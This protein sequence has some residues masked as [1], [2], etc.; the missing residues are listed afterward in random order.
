LDSFLLICTRAQVDAVLAEISRLEGSEFPYRHSE[1]ALSEVRRLFREHL[2]SLSGLVGEGYVPDED[3][4][5]TACAAACDSI[6]KSLDILGF[7]LRSTNVRNAFEIHGP[8]L[9]LAR[10]VLNSTVRKE[11]GLEWEI[12]DDELPDTEVPETKLLISSEW[13]FSPFTLVG[14]EELPGFVLIGLPATESSNPLLIP[15]AGH[16]LGHTI[17]H[18]FQGRKRILQ[19]VSDKIV[20]EVKTTHWHVLKQLFPGLDPATLTA[21]V[22]FKRSELQQA[23]EWAMRQSEEVFCDCVGLRIFGESYLHAFAYLVVPLRE[24]GRSPIYPNHLARV[25]SLVTTATTYGLSVPDGYAL[26]FKDLLELNPDPIV[27]SLVSVADTARC[28]ASHT[29]ASMAN[30]ILTTADIPARSP[31]KVQESV[32]TFRLMVPV[33]NAGGINNTVEGF[34]NILNAAWIAFLSDPFFKQPEYD[35]DM[36][37]HLSEIVL[38]SIEIFEIELRRAKVA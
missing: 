7:I 5:N 22:V 33:Q 34:A 32:D 15:L 10:R 11:I 1:Q 3:T 35:K 8:L 17:W 21:D 23:W 14:R 25:E 20:D 12:D 24:G 37:A 28:E 30:E 26:M 18:D 4:V 38:K 36:R 19:L 6:T 31:V 29:L 2:D 27:S 9:R 13:D 16:E